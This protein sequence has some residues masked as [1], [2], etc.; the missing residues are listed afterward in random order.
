MKIS[1][2]WLKTYINC[3]LPYQEVASALTSTGLEV[4]DS[5]YYESVKGGLKGIVT[6][7]VISC[8]QHPNADRLSLTK[9]DV[10]AAKCYQLSAVRP[11]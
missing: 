3:D 9:V 11:M 4:E 2:N 10:A 8:E 5:T 6:G 1:Y 7:K